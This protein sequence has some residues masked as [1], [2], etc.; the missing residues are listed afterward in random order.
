MKVPGCTKV[1]KE[2]LVEPEGGIHLPEDEKK[3]NV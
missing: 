2:M 1:S 3:G